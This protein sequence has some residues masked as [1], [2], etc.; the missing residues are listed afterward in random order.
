[1]AEH[2][3]QGDSS[4]AAASR[5]KSIA[6]KG[7]KKAR[8]KCKSSKPDLS[9]TRAGGVQ[10][11]KAKAKAKRSAGSPASKPKPEPKPEPEEVEICKLEWPVEGNLL[12]DTPQRPSP[13][14]S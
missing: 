8:P 7:R 2:L 13:R 9:A 4:G 5:K 1:M 11:R 10:K 3:A 6:A 12:A 14:P